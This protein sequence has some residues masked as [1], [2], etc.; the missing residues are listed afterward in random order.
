MK[1]RQRITTAR[2]L[3]DNGNNNGWYNLLPPPPPARRPRPHES[4]HWAIIGA[5]CCGLAVARQLAAHRPQDRIV[6]IEAERA[7]FG[8]SGRNSGFMLNVHTHGT[9]KD[10]GLIR[11]NM[12]LWEGGLEDLRRLVTEHRIQCDWSDWGR[13]YCAAGPEGENHMSEV[14]QSYD[15]LGLAY[16]WFDRAAMQGATATPF[17]TMGIRAHGS[18]LVQPA[19]LMR[20]LAETLPDNVDLYEDCPVNEITKGRGFELACSGNMVR[21]EKL[22]LA[23]GVFITDLGHCRNRMVPV[24]LYSSLT[25]PLTATER[26]PFRGIDEFALVPTSP[27]GSTVRLTRDGRI[28]M[29]NGFI[30]ATD[31]RFGPGGLKDARRLHREAIGRRWP[32]LADIEMADTWGGTIAFTRNDGAIFGKLG[33]NIYGVVTSDISPVTRGTMAGKLL[34]DYVVGADSELL[35]L[36]LGIPKAGLLPPDPLLRFAVNFQ[37]R[38]IRASGALEV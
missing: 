16:E 22:I 7:G 13:L 17:Y 25:R 4:A 10:L 33:E 9:A 8:S 2:V 26:E 6:L 23:S 34:A 32:A 29:R 31:K 27:N 15:R 1:T 38:R 18:A 3:P 12:R 28:L 21:A 37:F 35:R 5:G 19:A 20:S 36:Q 30:Y 24:G 14:A 11:R